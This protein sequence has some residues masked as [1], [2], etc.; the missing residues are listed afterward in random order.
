MCPGFGFGF[1][2][3]FENGF[4]LEPLE[5]SWEVQVLR[6]H[7]EN[8]RAGFLC[9]SE[10]GLFLLLQDL[11]LGRVSRS[12]PPQP[13]KPASRSDLQSHPYLHSCFQF[14]SV[15]FKRCFLFPWLYRLNVLICPPAEQTGLP[16]WLSGKKPTSL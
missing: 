12:P 9:E 4:D 11:A 13:G 2:F 3:G 1:G 8:F 5:G 16:R 6:S 14:E 15:L 10:L 7:S